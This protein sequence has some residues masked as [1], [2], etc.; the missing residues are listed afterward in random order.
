MDEFELDAGLHDRLR[1]IRENVRKL[2]EQLRL[3]DGDGDVTGKA[4]LERVPALAKRNFGQLAEGNSQLAIKQAWRLI[5]FLEGSD[6]ARLSPLAREALRVVELDKQLATFRASA[7][8]KEAAAR[9]REAVA[10]PADAAAV[11]AA[12]VPSA[13]GVEPVVVMPTRPDAPA[14]EHPQQVE[15]GTAP[16]WLLSLLRRPGPRILFAA[17]MLIAVA[18]S[19]AIWR[20]QAAFNPGSACIAIESASGP[21]LARHWTVGSPTYVPRPPLGAVVHTS[22]LP[23]TDPPN[24]PVQSIWTTSRYSYSE[25][26]LLAGPGGGLSDFRLRVGGWGDTYLS[27]Q[28]RA[29]SSRLACC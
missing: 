11:T 4:R 14:V 9:L 16:R 12:V 2:F 15:E 25:P 6:A 21:T 23:I 1:T 29:A 3:R 19:A 22:A 20:S 8:W 17:T 13:S 7:G 24:G 28:S 26:G 18:V 5:D 10:A 27:G